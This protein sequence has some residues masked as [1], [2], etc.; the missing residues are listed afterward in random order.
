M[1]H[2]SSRLVVPVHL[3][4]LLLL[5]L[6]EPTWWMVP[7]FMAGW[8][9]FGCLGAEV[10]LHRYFSH[11]SF[12]LTWMRYPLTWLACM[13][14]M[15]SPLAWAALHRQ[16]HQQSDMARDVH[17]PIHGRWSAYMGWQFSHDAA[18]GRARGVPWMALDPLQKW[19]HRN[20]LRIFWGTLAPLVVILPPWAALSLLVLPILASMHMENATNLF[21]HT[22][23]RLRYRTFETL[24]HSQNIHALGLLFWGQGYHNNHHANPRDYNF[25]HLPGEVDA[26]R[27]VVPALVRIDGMFSGRG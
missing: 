26:C 12:E 7:C 4:A 1:S 5:F 14:G 22:P 27:W 6:A 25:A 24:D 8:F 18:A 17:S 20:Y 15:W 16:H 3:L 11:R 19:V 2:Y 21:C 13:A 10:G 9:L 23:G